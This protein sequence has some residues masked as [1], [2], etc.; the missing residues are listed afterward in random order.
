MKNVSVVTS[1]RAEFGL[2][3]GVI[4]KLNN[5][6]DIKTNLIVT[7]THLVE[8]QGYTIREIRESGMEI[9]AQ[10]PIMDEVKDG[11]DMSCVVAKAV[12]GFGAF[13][14]EEPQDAVVILGDRYEMEGFA[15]AAV[16]A[17][18]PIVH[19]HGGEITKGAIDDLIRHS[20]TKLS[21][22][23][24]TSTEEYR[25]RVIQMGEE[26]ERVI[27]AGA[28][29]V[30]NVLGTELLSKEDIIKEI[31]DIS[32]AD[33]KVETPY[34][35]VTFHPVTTKP[36]QAT[37]QVEELLKALDAFSDMN[38]IIT[39]A[40]AD[41]GG[42][43]INE[44]FERYVKSH[45]NAVLVAS[46]GM[47]RYL[48]AMKYA[49]V[50][51]GN[52]SSGIIETPSFKI[53]TVNIGDRQEGRIRAKSVI[54]CDTSAGAITDAIQKALSADFRKAIAD[55]AS[56]YEKNGTSEIIASTIHDY[57]INDKFSLRKTFYDIK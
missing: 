42:A 24:F 53:P 34:A 40:N 11:F 18:V 8:E 28:L 39:K 51:I 26:P 52:S 1:T 29:G 31:N 15:I 38:F 50:V 33:F 47:K 43:E 3:R 17:N 49:E 5:Y 37:T 13:L 27:N 14:H 35:C 20:L 55:V 41:A 30:E 19:I 16:L 7:G 23:H 56:P 25:N 2:L 21:F 4:T 12:K 10:I 9:A 36:G 45:A 46:L 44:A 54:D 6:D 22:L 48:S 57:L 32:G